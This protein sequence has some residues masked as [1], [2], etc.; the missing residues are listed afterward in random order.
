M[1]FRVYFFFVVFLAFIYKEDVLYHFL[2]AT[3]V[4]GALGV[5]FYLIGKNASEEIGKQEGS[6]V[7]TSI[8]LVFTLLGTTLLVGRIYSILY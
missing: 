5:L 8:W 2:I 1:L 4:S 3:G 6:I 7:V